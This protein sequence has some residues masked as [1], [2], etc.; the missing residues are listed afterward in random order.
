MKRILFFEK[1]LSE[2]MQDACS[3]KYFLLIRSGES[4]RSYG[5]EIEK[6]DARGNRER[7]GVFGVS[8]ERKEAEAFLGRLWQGSALPVEL[9][10]LY[11]DFV[12]E[13]EWAEDHQTILTA[14]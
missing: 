10:A 1:V 9:A 8:E 6:T 3:I 2:G 13:R 12:S 14:C 11:D 5:V 4:G 7:D